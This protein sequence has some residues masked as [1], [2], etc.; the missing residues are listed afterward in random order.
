ML[1]F[2]KSS[3]NA[4]YCTFGIIKKPS[5]NMGAPSWFNNVLTY[6]GDGEVIKH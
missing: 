4:S 5:M 6:D 1:K 3:H 2:P